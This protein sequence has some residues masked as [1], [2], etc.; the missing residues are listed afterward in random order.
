MSAAALV[1]RLA[2]EGID[3]SLLADVAQELFAAEIERKALAD[4]RQNERERKARSRDRTG[5][6]GTGRERR[7]P[8]KDNNIKPPISEAN[9]SG[10]TP[11]A[12]PIKQVF[13]L[14]VE[15]LVDTG[16]PE[17]QARSLIGKWCKA[18]STAYVLQGLIECRSKSIVNPIEWLTKRFQSAQWVSPSGYEYRGTPEQVLREAERR[19]DM[20]TYWSVKAQLK[21]AA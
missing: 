6:S 19:N 7:G 13:D 1:A 2:Q 10:G 21:K 18:K 14:G 15:L 17:K 4:R 16:V 8:P 12:D 5:H 11:P 9:A 20:T 3:P